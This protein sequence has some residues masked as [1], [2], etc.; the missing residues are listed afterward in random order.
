MGSCQTEGLSATATAQNQLSGIGLVYDAAGNV[1]TDN[2]G[3]TYTYDAENRIATVAGYTYS[4][5]ADGRG[6]RR[7]TGLRGPCTGS[8]P[9]ARF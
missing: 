1:T 4:Y 2:L 3:N 8:V 5:D 9:A 6:W 7:P